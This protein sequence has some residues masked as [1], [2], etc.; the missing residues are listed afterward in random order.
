MYYEV[1]P[2]NPRAHSW[3]S[4]MGPAGQVNAAEPPR[5]NIHASMRAVRQVYSNQTVI[6]SVVTGLWRHRGMQQS[7]QKSSECGKAV[8]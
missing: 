7:E 6:S 8:T 5:R 1:D 4:T 2:K 3:I